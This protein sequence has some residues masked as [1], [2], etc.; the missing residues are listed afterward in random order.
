MFSYPYALLLSR[1][2]LLSLLLLL[3]SLALT[4]F[5]L[6]NLTIAMLTRITRIPTARALICVVLLARY[7]AHSYLHSYSQLLLPLLLLVVLLLL[8]VLVV[9]STIG[10][11]YYCY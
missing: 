8:R 1:L 2:L 11:S 3:L 6:S 10:L 4:M 9:H 5:T 7:S